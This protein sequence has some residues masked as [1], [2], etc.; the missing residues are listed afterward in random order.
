MRAEYADRYERLA[1]TGGI[2]HAPRRISRGGDR[3]PSELARKG[4]GNRGA[5]AIRR[6]MDAIEKLTGKE[7]A[8]WQRNVIEAHTQMMG[9]REP[10]EFTEAPAPTHTEHVHTP[11]KKLSTK[12]KAEQLGRSVTYVKEHAEELGGTKTRLGRWEFPA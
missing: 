2:L 10:R 6:R 11:I 9:L 7:M 12:Q 3:G 8:P 4:R 5:V 1:K